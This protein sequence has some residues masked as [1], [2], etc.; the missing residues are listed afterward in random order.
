MPPTVERPLFG[1]LGAARAQSGH[2]F[3]IGAVYDRRSEIHG[4]F[5]GQ[6]QYGI[7]TPREHPYIFLFTNRQ[8]LRHG[9]H[10]YFDD[11]GDF[12]YYGEGRHGDM[13]MDGG[14]AAIRDHVRNG[15]RL[16]VF[17]GLGSG[18]YRY[19]GEFVYC[20]HGIDPNA[21]DTA[22][23]LRNAIVFQLTPVDDEP[24]QEE[25]VPLFPVDSLVGATQRDAIVAV[26]TKQ[27]LFRRRVSTVEKECRLTGVMD[28]R[29]L[30]A[31]HIKPWA[32]S[33]DAERVSENNGLLLTP[34]A[35]LLFDHGWVSFED[36]GKL[37]VAGELPGRVKERLGLDL[38][39]GRRC[40]GFSPAQAAFLAYHRDCIYERRDLQDRLTARLFD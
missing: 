21:R 40:G 2:G 1:N 24:E 17:L 4:R 19:L 12:H 37:L 32:Q 5:G 3:S 26:R 11:D 34:S 6:S 7:S 14:N 9:Y 13:R 23:D 38:E 39:P 27:A 35:D 28:L 16:L 10:D 29:F 8:G 15:K 22:G 31:S 30:R 33:T 36:S 20:G 25:F 18:L